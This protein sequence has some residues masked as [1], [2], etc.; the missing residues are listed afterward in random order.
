M[1]LERILD[2][3]NHHQQRSTYGAVADLLGTTLRSLMQGCPRNQRHSWVVN[4][5]TGR[6]TDY[7]ASAIHPDLLRCSRVLTTSVELRNWLA[8]PS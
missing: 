8:D 1:N 5:K 3:L 2:A 7:P 4:Q 6:P